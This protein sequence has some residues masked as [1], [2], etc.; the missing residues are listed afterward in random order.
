M[1]LCFCARPVYDKFSTELY[2]RLKSRH[3][4][5]LSGVFI[6]NDGEESSYVRA[7]LPEAAVC[8]VAAFMEAHWSELDL[9]KLVYYEKKYACAPVWK[10]IYTDRFLINCDYEYC[11]KTTAGLFLF[12]EGVFAGSDIRYY[13]DETIATLQSYIA[14]VVGKACGVRYISQM[15]ARGKDSTHHF[16]L[17]DPYEYN[18]NFRSNYRDLTYSSGLWNTAAQ[19]LAEFEARNQRPKLMDL[20]STKPAFTLQFFLLPVLWLKNRRN[21]KY[22]NKYSYMYYKAYR[23]SCNILRYYI[24]Y[25]VSKRYY[26]KPDYTKKFV[27]YPLHYQPEA[28]TIVCAQKYEKQIFFIDSWAKSLPADTML[29]VKEHYSLLGNRELGFYK[30]LR[31]YPNV[32]LIDPWEDTFRL[33]K[34]SVAVTT[35]TGTAGWEAMLLRKPVFLG[36][37]IYYENAPGI[38]KTEEIFGNYLR[39]MEGW[40]EPSR[41]EIIQ[42]LCEYFTSIYEGQVYA[43]SSACYM[44]DNID[45]V[46]ASLYQQLYGGG[47]FHE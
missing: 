13:Y 16:F 24:R 34:G 40:K 6:T 43:A 21:P 33:I 2:L 39:S 29:Y 1:K 45:K 17:G 31:H 7:K 19:F 25:K 3:D 22:N 44:D 10:L 37:S 28:S 8:E 18:L 23:K 32:L 20:V 9:E 15:T 5:M 30:Q 14:Y 41:E 26:H 38:I 47:A 4:P 42:Y 27:Y 35:L 11:V 36:G 12:F 46:A